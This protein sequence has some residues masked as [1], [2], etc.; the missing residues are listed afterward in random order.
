MEKR[1]EARAAAVSAGDGALAKMPT[2]MLRAGEVSVRTGLSRTTLW[3]LERAGQFPDR[4]RLSANAVGWLSE[5]VD[6]WIA[7]RVRRTDV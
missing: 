3:R 4:R 2:K 6:E 1:G 5:E 7:T